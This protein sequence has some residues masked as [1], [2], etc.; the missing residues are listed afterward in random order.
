MASRLKALVAVGL[1]GCG[2]AKYLPHGPAL[3]EPD[4]E[5][6]SA[7]AART[8]VYT[9]P[10]RVSFPVWP[11][12]VWGVGYDLDLVLVSRHPRY[13]MHEYAR[14]RT[15]QGDLWLAK[16][17]LE[18]TMQQS[19][20]ADLD[21][22]ERWVPE[23]PIERRRG[24]VEVDD[25]STDDWLDLTLS[26][27]N[28]E[29]EPVRIR[30]EGRRPGRKTERKR[31]GSTMGHSADVAMAALDIPH[32]E[33]ARR[34]SVE[35]NGQRWKIQRLLG[36]VPV[37]VALVQTQGGLA[38][39]QYRI[40]EQDGALSAAFA[41]RSG[42]EAITQWAI[43][44]QS[45]SVIVSQ[46]D[47][48]RQLT[49]TFAE[50]DG[51]LELASMEVTQFG[52]E[53]PPTHIDLYP[54]LP[55]MRRPFEG[56]HTSRF[57]V[58]INGQRGVAFGRLEASWEGDTAVVQMIPEEPS[59]VADR[60]MRTTVRYADGAAEVAIERVPVSARRPGE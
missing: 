32:K 43:E 10:P 33:F 51:A 58:D 45:G 1:A 37:Q 52:R 17:A 59:W 18:E 35:I 13:N 5:R 41:L 7:D 27:R 44:Q 55:D 26:Y 15:P 47:G 42:A 23:L 34:A 29:G 19:I 8:V 40:S 9:A 25:Q 46:D 53:T 3:S 49:Y 21:G 48:L 50:R 14:V 36:L 56:T 2:V 6:M 39:G 31:S 30:Y 28:L 4:R 54:H 24:A 11:V 22:L 57:A 12:S 38:T 20:V 16:D 60:P